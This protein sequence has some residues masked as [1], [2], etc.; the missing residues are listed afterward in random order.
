ML[1]LDFDGVVCDGLLECAAVTWHAANTATTAGTPRLRQAVSEVPGEFLTT[2]ASVRPLSR[3]LDDFMVTNAVPAGRE[4]GR[5]QFERCREGVGAERLTAQ[6]AVGEQ[7]RAQWRVADFPDWLALHTIYPE[8]AELLSSTRHAVAI[9]SAK[10]ADSVWA[11]LRH[12]RLAQHITSVVGSCRDKAPVLTALTGG[13]HTSAEPL[14]F[15]DDNLE[16]V[17]AAGSLPGIEP[18]WAVWGYHTPED[19]DTA[20]RLGIRS[21]T[22][23]QLGDLSPARAGGPS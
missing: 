5:E 1:A 17:R 22:L 23:D 14:V 16:H 8:V 7:I 13:L 2:F 19:V 20:A 11:I 12:H 9:V 15:I 18:R 10:D 4:V 6:A 3:T 21:L